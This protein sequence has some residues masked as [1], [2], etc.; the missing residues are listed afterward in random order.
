MLI[1]SFSAI[2][3]RSIL[4]SVVGTKSRYR[5]D[6]ENVLKPKGNL[7]LADWNSIFDFQSTFG[8]WRRTYSYTTELSRILMVDKNMTLW[9][10]SV[11]KDTIIH[12]ILFYDYAI[13]IFHPIETTF[14]DRQENSTQ[15]CRPRFYG[16]F[17]VFLWS[18]NW[19]KYGQKCQTF[20]K[21]KNQ[22]KIW[23]LV[24]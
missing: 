12:L 13:P 23:N 7:F 10:Q 19:S 16:I 2:V 15:N 14:F 5:W 21:S 4:K 11:D 24:S 3:F 18:A 8:R 9:I 20:F 1:H 22:A 6:K 17:T